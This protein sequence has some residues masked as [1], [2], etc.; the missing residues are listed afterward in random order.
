MGAML[1]HFNSLLKNLL[2]CDLSEGNIWL[3]VGNSP[4]PE[5]A[6]PD[7]PNSNRDDFSK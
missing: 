4:N 5:D 3:C 1:G 7:Q 2:H 6:I